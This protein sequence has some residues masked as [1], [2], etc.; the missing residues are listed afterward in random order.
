MKLKLRS[1]AVPLRALKN[2]W[3]NVD[4]CNMYVPCRSLSSGNLVDVKGGAVIAPQSGYTFVE[5]QGGVYSTA[6]GSAARQ[7]LASG[8][9]QP[10]DVSKYILLMYAGYMMASGAMRVAI[11]DTESSNAGGGFGLSDG[12]VSPICAH[13]SI[14][15]TD[16]IQGQQSH[17]SHDSGTLEA[18]GK[19]IFDLIGTTGH[20]FRYALFDPS[21]LDVESAAY[22]TDTGA[23]IRA[24]AIQS[25]DGTAPPNM[26][27]PAKFR[28][29]NVVVT[30]I[31]RFDFTTLPSDYLLG[32]HSMA[33]AW[34]NGNNVIWPYWT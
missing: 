24:N 10:L 29:H 13:A 19:T 17:N 12:T 8:S 30:G 32:M 5:S 34:G 6:P 25:D 2:S 3:E 14:G 21:T 4:S 1:S 20:F 18:L 16:S 26:T 7:S 31:A 27:I 28:M 9:F 33:A 15:R 23:L 11:G 22:R